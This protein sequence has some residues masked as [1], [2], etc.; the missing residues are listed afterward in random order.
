MVEESQGNPPGQV[1]PQADRVA[2][3]VRAM[4]ANTPAPAAAAADA[5]PDAEAPIAEEPKVAQ[6][7]QV[8]GAARGQAAPRPTRRAPARQVPAPP[9]PPVRAPQPPDLVNARAPQ[10]AVPPAPPGFL[11][12]KKPL[13]VKMDP[14]DH[15]DLKIGLALRGRDMSSVVSTLIRVFNSDPDTWLTLMDRAVDERVLLGDALAPA[16]EELLARESLVEFDE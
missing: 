5:D 10:I 2:E 15:W 8:R 13:Q 12:S 11:T 4:R 9:P 16:F 14:Q 6:T 1:P 3:P 7:A